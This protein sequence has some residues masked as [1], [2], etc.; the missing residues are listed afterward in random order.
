[1]QRRWWGGGG[2]DFSS[3]AP[4]HCWGVT[5]GQAR[6][7]SS[8]VE[9]V[10]AGHVGHNSSFNKDGMPP[11]LLHLTLFRVVQLFNHFIVRQFR[12]ISQNISYFAIRRNNHFLVYRIRS[13][14]VSSKWDD[15]CDVQMIIDIYPDR[16]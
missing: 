7:N 6:D 9:G 1:M 16:L 5:A 4:Q 15:F 13:E 10:T 8:N 11:P 12:W 14:I 3:I 2:L